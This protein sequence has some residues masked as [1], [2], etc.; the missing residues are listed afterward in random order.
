MPAK[1]YDHTNF[2][3]GPRYRGAGGA[4]RPGLCLGVASSISEDRFLP[5][6]NIRCWAKDL[7]DAACSRDVPISTPKKELACAAWM[8]GQAQDTTIGSQGHTGRLHQGTCDQDLR[9]GCRRKYSDDN[10]SAQRVLLCL[11]SMHCSRWLHVSQPVKFCNAS[12][13][14]L[15]DLS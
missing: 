14:Y 7:A 1:Y 4:A 6:A 12:F 13:H 2:S 5:A 8:T 3:A 10:A 9:Q 11:H 15:M